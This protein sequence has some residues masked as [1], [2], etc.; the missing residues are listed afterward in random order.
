MLETG[1]KYDGQRVTGFDVCVSGSGAVAMS[2]ALSL[3]AEG[4]RVAWARAPAPVNLPASDVRT[5]AL[6]S[7]AIALLGRL[8]IWPALKPYSSP[9]Q[10]MVV[11]GDEG[12][13]LSFSS[14]QQCVS[15]LAWIVDA[16]ALDRLLAEALRFAPRVEIVPP[17]SDQGAPVQ[18]SLLAICEGKHSSSRA[19]LGVT[20]S[21][22]DYS[23]WGVAARL[24]ATQAHQGVARQWFRSPDVLALLP[25]NQPDPLAS[26]GL[27]WSVPKVRAEHLLTLSAA[28]FEQ[29]LQQAIIQSD[30]AAASMVGTLNLTSPVAAW[31]LALAQAERWTGPGWVL[32]GDAAH[33]VHPLAGQGLNLGLADVD[34]LVSI[35]KQARLAEP[36][37]TLGDERTLRRYA[38]QREWPTKAMAGLTDG[39]LHLFA[40][41]R[42]PIKDLRN[43]GMTL[44]QRLGPV[45]SWLIG[46]AL[47]A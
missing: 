30:P 2:L 19:A 23:H 34:A 3:S 13:A 8:R 21:K 14:W 44:V 11:R 39:L 42:R 1:F 29:A 37:R 16:A 45:K 41:E 38:R 6:N 31:P 24:T 46:Q 22:Q 28:D 32:L 5:Y 12:G 26:Y 9:V 33:Q 43:A 20:F 35:L 47:D 18:A 7:R 10:E 36:W 17:V 25:F 4:F 15:E 40:D 27:V